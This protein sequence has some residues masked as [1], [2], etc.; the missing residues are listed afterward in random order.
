DQ[1]TP[2]TL[3]PDDATHPI[4]AG[5]NSFH[6]GSSSFHNVV[7]TTPGSTLVA[8]WSNGRSLVAT[9]QRSS[10]MV[11]GLN[12][13]PPSSDVQGDLWQATTDGALLMANALR[14][15]GQSPAPPSLSLTWSNILSPQITNAAITVTIQARDASNQ[16]V[17][18]FVGPVTLRDGA[19]G[20]VV[21]NSI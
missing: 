7:A 1:F 17:T 10:G 19:T 18:N 6:G 14:V 11:V 5:V 21:S 2:L 8:H 16:I 3:V 12:F 13:F 9:K 4:L 15:A 20:G